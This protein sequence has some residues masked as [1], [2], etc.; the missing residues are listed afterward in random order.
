MVLALGVGAFATR[1]LPRH[2]PRLLQ[3]AP[4]PRRR[5]R[6][7][8]MSGEQD[9]Q[10]M[11]GSRQDADHVLDVSDRTSRS[12]A[13]RARRLLQQGRD[14][15]AAPVE[16]PHVLWLIATITATLTAFYMFRSSS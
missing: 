3:G 6:H 12:P 14:P 5:Q 11:G 7:H 8:G 1:D 10:K 16:R 4:L 9:V 2:D 15:L 13:R